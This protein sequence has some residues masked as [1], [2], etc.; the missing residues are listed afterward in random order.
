[1]TPEFNQTTVM[2]AELNK[3]VNAGPFVPFLIVMS[4]GKSYE[5]PTPDH[6]TITRLLREVFV[7]KDDGTAVAINLL[8]VTAIERLEL[9]RKAE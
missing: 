1:M 6:L 5:V 3:R 9:A 7:E 4:S 8:H 2:L